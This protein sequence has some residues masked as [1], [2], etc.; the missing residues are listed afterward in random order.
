MCK[1]GNIA[2]PASK[3]K[4]RIDF[5]KDELKIHRG[6]TYWYAEYGE[7]ALKSWVQEGDRKE[8]KLRAYVEALKEMEEQE[9]NA[10]RLNEL[11]QN[12]TDSLNRSIR[13]GEVPNV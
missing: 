5:L 7:E 13:N 12:Y 11:T 6:F 9:R 8:E 2:A 4:K 3:L 10:Q 1:L